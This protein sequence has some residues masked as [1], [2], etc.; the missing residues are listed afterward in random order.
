M[1]LLVRYMVPNAQEL[2]D[3]S[4]M[5]VGDET[6]SCPPSLLFALVIK[7]MCDSCCNQTGTKIHG[8]NEIDYIFTLRAYIT[9]LHAS[10]IQLTMINVQILCLRFSIA[11]GTNCARV[12]QY[13]FD[14][15]RSG[16]ILPRLLFFF[17][18]V[19]KELCNACYTEKGTD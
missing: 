3:I 18:L 16:H 2:S 13:F 11:C 4:V 17:A 12:E 14:D 8:F 7:D 1:V 9:F 5:L 15:G 6:S 19:I 10:R